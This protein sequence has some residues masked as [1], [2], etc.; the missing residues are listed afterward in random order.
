MLPDQSWNCCGWQVLQVVGSMSSACDRV[1]EPELEPQ[2]PT[3]PI[4]QLTKVTKVTARA[5]LPFMGMKYGLAAFAC[6]N[7]TVRPR[8]VRTTVVLALALAPAACHQNAIY[9]PPPP[10][11]SPDAGCPSFAND[12]YPNVIQPVCVGCHSPDGG[13]SKTLLLTYDQVFGEAS[14][15]RNQVFSSCAMPPSNAPS[16]LTDDQRQTLFDWLHCGAPNNPVTD[17]GAGD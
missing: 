14:E 15:I 5:T 3:A 13:E 7:S 6:H 4:V 12:V 8:R 10:V 2:P 17:G 11:A 9:C 16:M 1:V